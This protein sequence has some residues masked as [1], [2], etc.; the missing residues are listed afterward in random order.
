MLD[1]AVEGCARLYEVVHGWDKAG[2]DCT[3]WSRQDKAGQDWTKL[4]KA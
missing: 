1:M 4:G 2:Q 3:S